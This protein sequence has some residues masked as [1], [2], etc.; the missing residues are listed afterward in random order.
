MGAGI[1]LAACTSTMGGGGAPPASAPPTEQ[2]TR[3]AARAAPHLVP[4]PHPHTRTHTHPPTTPPRPPPIAPLFLVPAARPSGT[5]RGARQRWQ[6]AATC[7]SCTATTKR[8]PRGPRTEWRAS[9]SALRCTMPPRVSPCICIGASRPRGARTAEHICAGLP[10]AAAAAWTLV[11][12]RR[13]AALPLPLQAMRLLRLTALVERLPARPA[14]SACLLTNTHQPNER[15]RSTSDPIRPPNL[16]ALL[17]LRCVRPACPAPLVSALTHPPLGSACALQTRRHFTGWLR[18]VVSTKVRV[19]GMRRR[20][21]CG[22]QQAV[23]ARPRLCAVVMWTWK[24][25][26]AGRGTP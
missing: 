13:R 1:S 10:C 9:A 21:R 4:P 2:R 8:W 5:P 12:A 3:P 14:L 6:R 19:C 26:K 11:R 22:L 15:T 25:N 24:W 16:V 18:L 7:A 17:A 20:R 23:A